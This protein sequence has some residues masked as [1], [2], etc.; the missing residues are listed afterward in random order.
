MT[1]DFFFYGT[2]R[3]AEVRR[4]VLGPGGFSLT[5]E[6]AMLEGYRCAPV[7]RG[8]FPGIVPDAEAATPGVL[9]R[10]A[11]LDAAAR[12]S[13]FESDGADYEIALKPVVIDG[14]RRAKAW[15]CIPT[16][17]LP[18]EAGEWRFEAWKLQWRP[19]FLKIAKAAMARVTPAELRRHRLDWW[20]RL[21][22]APEA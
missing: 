3:D 14:R 5:A 9:V 20:S 22:R 17:A 19:A 1:V 13:Y 21:S 12:T 18:V 7:E 6:P 4:I 8:R 15:V 16:A 2:L 11:S 10:R